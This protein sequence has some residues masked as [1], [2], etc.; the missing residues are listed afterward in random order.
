MFLL[1][2]GLVCLGCGRKEQPQ[3]P[4]VT[5]APEEEAP[6]TPATAEAETPQDDIALAQGVAVQTIADQYGLSPD[7]VAKVQA[8]QGFSDEDLAIA[9]FLAD[10]TPDTGDSTQGKKASRH[11]PG[12]ASK[13]LAFL[14]IGS[15]VAWADTNVLIVIVIRIGG[16]R[17]Q[18]IGWGEVAHRL[19]IH[20]GT[21]NKDRVWLTKHLGKEMD[22][23]FRLIVFASVIQKW[24][25]VPSTQVIAVFKTGEPHM[26]VFIAV[27]LG[28]RTKKPWP[29]LL[30]GKPKR[31]DGWV[32]LFT[33]NNV[34]VKRPAKW[35][36]FP[37]PKR[38]PPGQA[39]KPEKPA[40]G[41][42]SAKPAKGAAA[43][44]KGKPAAK[45]APPS[46]PKAGPAAKSSKAK[47]TTAGTK[48]ASAAQKKPAAQKAGSGSTAKPKGNSGKDHKGAQV[49]PKGG[50]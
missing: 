34:Q 48:S 35:A 24:F 38:A 20:P 15:G 10:A 41:G 11:E 26:D 46:K 2:L 22:D 21:F 32:A 14:D 37:K 31:P 1:L 5:F 45:R 16:W 40:P 30:R 3:P 50:A 29:E 9:F 4:S 13:V 39:A 42:P 12:P 18:G 49:A 25:R 43:P 44:A 47:T 28:A 6:A 36:T 17:S 23:E 27:Y 33:S 7:E 8:E 19:N